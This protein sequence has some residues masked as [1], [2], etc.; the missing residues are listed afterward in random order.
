MFKISDSPTL[1][2]AIAQEERLFSLD[3]ARAFA[4]LIGIVFHG[5][6]SLVSFLPP[7]VWAVKDTQSSVPVDV[8]YYVAHV[9][10]MQAF[11]MLSGFFAH[12]LYHRRGAQGFLMHRIKRIGVPLLLFWPLMMVATQLLWTWGY[13]QMGYLA[14]NPETAKLGYWEI[15]WGNFKSFAWLNYGFPL[16]HL[17]FLYMLLWF[18]AAVWLLRPVFVKYIDKQRK[19][20][21]IADR[22]MTFLIGRWWGSL[23]IGLVAVP[24]MWGMKNG[25]GIDTPD[26]SLLP[27]WAP[28][29]VYGLH[30]TFGWFLHRQ[31]VLL[32]SIKK[33]WK[34]N[35]VL[36]LIFIA[37]VAFSFFSVVYQV[38]A[39]GNAP[40]PPVDPATMQ[41]IGMIYN[42]IYGLASITSIFAFTSLM[43]AFFSRS[44]SLIRYLS[45]ASY[46][47]YLIHLPVV[48]LF[49]ILVA[50]YT[51]HWSIK[52]ATILWPSLLILLISYH[53]LVRHTFLGKL[54]NGRKYSRKEES[55]ISTAPEVAR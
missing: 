12:M 43:L 20:R 10:R 42:S 25:F 6:S 14:M 55:R 13:K 39:Q 31:P 7:M 24:A 46:W 52:V 37:L 26:H 17:W 5:V 21:A 4:L 45:D 27:Q 8:F 9:F 22:F 23:V 36:S 53:F 54:L 2:P 51:W 18:C 30:F 32:E 44:N 49:Q 50:P 28:F 48:V 47:M 33:Y 35:A 41:V 34:V 15:V 11:F 38:A 40:Q 19:L 29:I 16:T 3:A 1:S